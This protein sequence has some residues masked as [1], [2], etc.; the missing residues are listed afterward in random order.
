MTNDMNIN[1]IY[2]GIRKS[3][4][5]E[6]G[7]GGHATDTHEYAAS[8]P[9]NLFGVMHPTSSTKLAGGASQPLLPYN[10][11]SSHADDTKTQR[12]THHHSNIH[13]TKHNKTKHNTLDSI[14]NISANWIDFM[15]FGFML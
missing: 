4:L 3:T 14:A 6:A 10:G 5:L 1:N 15:T 13:N 11:S 2:E 9:V 12:H 8:E 7:R